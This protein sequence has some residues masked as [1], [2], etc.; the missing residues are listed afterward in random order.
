[1]LKFHPWPDYVIRRGFFLSILFLISALVM[2]VWVSAS[3]FTFPFLSNCAS[4]CMTAGAI[5]LAACLLG[6]IFLEDMIRTCK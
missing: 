3:P 6:G 4:Y 2:S 5:V 1:M